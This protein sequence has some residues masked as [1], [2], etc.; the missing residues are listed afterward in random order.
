[1]KVTVVVG[2]MTVTVAVLCPTVVEG[3]MEN[4]SRANSK[5]IIILDWAH[6]VDRG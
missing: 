2:S 1:M 6:G 5:T 4:R 3:K